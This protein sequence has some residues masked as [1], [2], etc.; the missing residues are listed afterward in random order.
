MKASFS[1]KAL[2]WS[3]LKSMPR[4]W[5]FCMKLLSLHLGNQLL[6]WHGLVKCQICQQFFSILIWM[7]CQYFR[8]DIRGSVMLPDFLAQQYSAGVLLGVV[9]ISLRDCYISLIIFQLFY[10]LSN[11][12][13]FFFLLSGELDPWSIWGLRSRWWKDICKRSSGYEVCWH[14]IF[15]SNP[16]SQAQR[17]SPQKNCAFDFCAWLVLSYLFP[18]TMLVKGFQFKIYVHLAAV[19]TQFCFFL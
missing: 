19:N 5:G 13:I 1:F 17:V 3:F 18:E 15:G 9:V 11:F 6:S 10:F 12:S 14:P 4:N 2:Q 7:W 8:W 16:A